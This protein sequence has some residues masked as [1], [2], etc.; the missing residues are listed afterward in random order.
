[1]QCDEV[2]KREIPLFIMGIEA[3]PNMASHLLQFRV[4]E[5]G[6]KNKPPHYGGEKKP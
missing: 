5:E 4:E 6:G 2:C 3:L 1:M